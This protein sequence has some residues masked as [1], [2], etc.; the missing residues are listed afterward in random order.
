MKSIYL[1]KKGK[2]STAFETREV[3]KPVPG[4]GEVG[5]KV[6]CFGLNYADV[7]ARNGLYR[8]APDIPCV[9][10]YEV[11]GEIDAV[12]ED[13]S[14]D[15]MGKR[16]VA[17]TRFGGYSEYAVT[18][19]AAIVEIGELDGGK[20][21]CIATQFVTAWYMAVETVNLRPE[22]KVLI[23]AGAGGVGIALIQMCK[24]KGCY[25][26]ATA[27]S[28]DKLK[29]MKAQGVDF[30]INYRKED[31]GEKIEDHLRGERLDVTFNAIAGSTFKKDFKL[32]GSGGK[33]VLFGGAERSGKKWG[34]LSTLNFVRKMGLMIPIGLMMR[35]KS[36][37]GVNMLKIGDNKPKVLSRCLNEVAS[38]VIAGSLDPVVGARFDARD[39]AEAH[40]FLE[41]RKSVGKV[42][43][44][45]G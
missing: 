1:V 6:E 45:W 38:E 32:I 29:F 30:V 37:I 34:I 39:I 7:Q 5:I 40:D 12:G 9:L 35:S 17:F 27:G 42:V 26:Y 22:D 36:L 41:S 21:L 13:V 8:E 23:H 44:Y 10:G 24:K 4:K 43:V 2:A 33:V 3:Q 28:D 20:A 14:Q 25:V 15:L 31:Y 18:P 16:V 11:V 19:E